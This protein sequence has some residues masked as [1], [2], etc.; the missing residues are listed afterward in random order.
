L[1]AIVL[2]LAAAPV[3]AQDVRDAL[4]AGD[5]ICEFGHDGGRSL[6]AELAGAPAAT[7]LLLVYE[8]VTRGSAQVLSTR[9]SG[10]RPVRVHATRKAVHFIEHV[11]SS[12]RV[13]T[14]TACEQRKARGDIETCV[15]YA[16]R[17][18]WHFDDRIDVDPDLAFAQLPSGAVA[19]QCE[20]WRI[21]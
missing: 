13:T 1:A 18:A 7:D 12:A 14:L 19:G 17:H 16:A 8:A 2:M 5:L 4:G 15:R 21:D 6:V 9:G 11:G 3:A 10:R 20:P